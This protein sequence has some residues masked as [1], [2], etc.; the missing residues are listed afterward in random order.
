[1]LFSHFAG[2]ESH[3]RRRSEVQCDDKA[4]RQKHVHDV[5]CEGFGSGPDIH[6]EKCS[7][8]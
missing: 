2:I 5:R 1:M 7:E 8:K 3:R 6:I 4:D